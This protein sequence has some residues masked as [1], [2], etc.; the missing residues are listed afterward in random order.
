M[1]DF[2][3][4]EE[5]KAMQ[6]VHMMAVLTAML[7]LIPVSGFSGENCGMLGG[8]CRDA[9][10]K[11]EAAEAGA[12]DDCNEKQDCC[13]ARAVEEV[14]CCVI[15]FEQKNSGPLNCTAPEQGKCVKGSASTVPCA[16]LNFCK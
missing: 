4:G 8:T 7:L 2:T 14:R 5:R 11:N 1:P 10:G 6:S 16:K 12:F 3:E 13:V 15:S 9:C